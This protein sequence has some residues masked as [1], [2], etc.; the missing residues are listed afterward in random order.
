MVK[1]TKYYDLLGVSPTATEEE[2]KKGY[3]KMAIRFHPDK[4]PDG[5]EKFKEISHAYE[6]L[7]DPQKREIY[8]YGGEAA[9]REGGG[10]GG[11]FHDPRDI[12]ESFFKSAF[13]QG[14]SRPTRGKDQVHK[15][16]VSLEEL[17]TGSTKSLKLSRQIVCKPCSGTG[18][19]TKTST[20]CSNCNGKGSVA[21]MRHIGPGMVQ[22][23]L[24]SCSHCKGTGESVKDSDRCENCRG[25]KVIKEEKIIKVDIPKGLKNNSKITMKGMSDEFPGIEPGDLIFVIAEKSHSFYVRRADDLYCELEITLFEALGGMNQT[26]NTLD[27]RMLLLKT[28]PGEVISFGSCRS[29]YQEGMPKQRNPIERG[30]LIVQFKVKFPDSNWADVETIKKVVNGLPKPPKKEIPSGA[31]TVGMNH[32]VPSDG[33]GHDS[34]RDSYEDDD[35]GHNQGSTQCQVG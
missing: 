3:K 25:N 14:S 20:R 13:D 10:G 2:L 34:N 11:G 26:I 28:D 16:Q 9:I 32:F 22:Q 1:E 7:S 35:E 31:I 18:S 15:L 27:K 19:K 33:N 23:F 30:N 4:N 29:I 17:Y 6:V 5:A 24:S 12:F 21:S 8:D